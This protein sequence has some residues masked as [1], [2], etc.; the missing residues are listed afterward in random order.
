MEKTEEVVALKVDTTCVDV[1]A[2]NYKWLADSTAK[3]DGLDII[4]DGYTK[5]STKPTTKPSTVP[6]TK[7][8][9]SNVRR[10]QTPS[11]SRNTTPKRVEKHENTNSTVTKPNTQNTNQTTPTEIEERIEKKADPVKLHKA[12]QILLAEEKEVRPVNK[13]GQTT[14][15]KKKIYMNCGKGPKA[16]LSFTEPGDEEL[17]ES[18]LKALK[19]LAAYLKT[20]P[21]ETVT[22]SVEGEDSVSRFV[23]QKNQSYFE[24]IKKQL[25]QYGVKES[26]VIMSGEGK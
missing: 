6:S 8:S 5:P 13:I 3:A 19:Q 21:Q 15:H 10:P 4:I 9:S 22:F 20:H 16:T 12:E 2:I 7:P 24:K 23:Q 18:K 26:Q 17:T 14:V 25:I 1:V 11:S